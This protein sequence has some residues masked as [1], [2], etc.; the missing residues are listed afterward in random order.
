[1]YAVAL[2]GARWLSSL[3]EHNRQMINQRVGVR[4]KS[5]LTTAVFTKVCAQ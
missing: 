3:V 1:L 5:M 4:A 2:F